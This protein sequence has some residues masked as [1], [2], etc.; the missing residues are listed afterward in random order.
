MLSRPSQMRMDPSTLTQFTGL[1]LVRTRYSCVW[2]GLIR[3]KVLSA[4]ISSA[5]KLIR[6]L[7]TGCA[8]TPN[9]PA[10]SLIRVSP[11]LVAG[12]GV[13]KVND[14]SPFA[15]QPSGSAAPTSAQSPRFALFGKNTSVV[16]AKK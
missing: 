15:V 4:L 5:S 10:Y 16:L 13:T 8:Q 12:P 9:T 7:V 2:R 6:Q 3:V 1:Y 11:G 14:P